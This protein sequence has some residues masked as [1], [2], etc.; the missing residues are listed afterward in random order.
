[1]ATRA[2]LIIDQGTTF[3]STINISQSD[4]TLFQLNDYSARGK[5]KKAFSS[6]TSVDFTC[7]V[8]ENSPSQ[9]TVT[10]SLNSIQTASLNSGRY[11]YDVE[12][13]TSDSPAIVTRIVE[14]QVEVTPSVSQTITTGGG[15]GSDSPS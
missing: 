10:I 7:V 9:D 15:I 11:V 5:I 4:G 2:D 13:F 1:M 12:V 14:G 8:N 3:S 6:S